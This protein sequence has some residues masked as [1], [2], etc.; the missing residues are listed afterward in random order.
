MRLL[1]ERGVGFPTSAGVVPIVPTA[2]IYDLG[3]GDPTF[4]PTPEMAYA[5]AEKASSE[6]SESG[7]VGAGTGATV[8]K[9]FGLNRAMKGGFGTASER[10]GGVLVGACAVVNA[11]GDV[12]D[13][14]TG[15]WL[16][17]ARTAD[18]MGRAAT[19]E[20]FLGG[21]AREPFA[22]G[23]T[24]LAVVATS[25]TLTREELIGVA[26]MAH[27]ALFRA[28]R[29]VHTPMDGDIVVSLSTGAAERKGNPMQVAALAGRA[30]EKAITDAV[31]AT[32][33]AYGLPSA[34][35]MQRRE[36]P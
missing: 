15:E 21:Y 34:G 36:R 26:R 10:A 8:G 23:N 3:V 17:G 4:R 25:E 2:V 16:A 31:R 24:T 7:S 20:A 12:V 19:E 9:I 33:G 27:G 5:A 14:L 28:I 11:F 30:L 22:P 13:P 32:R 6:M 29:P 18:G 1:E 35:D